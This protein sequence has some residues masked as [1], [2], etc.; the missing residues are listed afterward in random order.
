MSISLILCL[1][2]TARPANAPM[3]CCVRAQPSAAGCPFCALDLVRDTDSV[4][5]Q[6][7]L[8]RNGKKTPYRC[9]LCAVADAKTD[10]GDVKIVAASEK[11]GKAVTI[12][13][14]AG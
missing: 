6:V 13:R 7:Q 2:A 12:T 8:E 5:N 4:D 9:V 14:K 10:K 3:D 11:K 1:V